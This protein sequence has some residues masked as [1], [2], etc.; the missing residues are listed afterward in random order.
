M[1]RLLSAVL[2]AGILL[3]CIVMAADVLDVDKTRYI[4]DDGFLGYVPDR[5]IVVLKDHVEVDHARE[6]QSPMA[7]SQKSG[8]SDLAQRFGVVH[9]R[10]QFLGSDL[11]ANANPTREAR[12][13]ARHYKVYLER[14][15]LDEAIKAYEQHPMVERVE[16]IGVHTVFATPNDP[17]YDDPPGGYAYDQ[18]HYWD[19][20]G[21][22]ADQAWN[23]ETGSQNVIVGDLD[24]GTKYDHGDLGGSNP[25]GP[26]DASTNGNIWINTNEVVGNGVDDDGNGYVDDILGWDFVESTDWYSYSCIDI[27]CGGADNDPSDGDGHGTHTAGTI[28]AITNNGYSVAGVAGGYGDGT[29]N[30]GGNGVKVVPCRI[31]YVLDYWIYGATGV[32]IMD[33][34]AEAMY[35]MADLKDAGWN[36]AAINCSFGSSNS[37]GLSS[38]ASYLIARDVVICVAAGNSSSSSASYLSS[39][40]DC[41]DVAATDQSGNPASFT[42]YGSWV[43]IA[44]P[45]VDVVSTITDPADPGGDYIAAMDGT[46]MSCPHVAGVVGLLESYNPSL[47]ATDKIN[48]ITDPANTNPYG[49]SLD[50]G[51]GIVDAYKCLQAAGGGCDLAADFSGSPT[52]GCEPLTVS[53]TDLSSGSGIDGWSWTFGDGGSS[54]SQNPNHTYNGPGTYSVSLTVSSSG[55]GCDDTETKT[56]YITVN[57]LPTA[58]FTG[59]PTSG[60]EPLTVDFTDQSSNATSW[61]W[62]FGDGAGT[63]T[64]QNPSYTYKSA[65][66]YTVT[67]TANNSCGSDVE[68]KVDYIT[69]DPCIAPT[70]AFTGS[71]TSGDAPLTVDFTDQSSNATSWSWDFGDGSGTSTQQN[72]SYTYDAPGT[73]TVTLTA[74]NS[75]GSDDEVKTD[76]ITVTCT[77]P[78]ANFTGSPTSGYAPLTVDFSDQSTGATSWSWDFGDGF[79]SSTQ[80]NPSYTYDTPGTYTVALTAANSCGNDIETK[81]NYI[82]VSEAPSEYATLPYSTGF[83]SGSFDAYWF[84][85]TSSSE[86]RIQITSSNSPRGSYH[87]TMDDNT[88]GGDYAQNEAWLKVDLAGKSDVEL[89]FWWKEFSD[90][91]HTQDGVFFSDNGGSSF[92]KVYNLTGGSTTYQEI[93]LD[94]DQL[95]SGAGLSLTSTFVIK[96]QQYD[97]YSITTDGM[98]FDDI[99]VT[100]LDAPPVADF[101]GSPTSGSFPLEVTFTDQSSGNPTSWNWDF[102]DGS[103]TSTQQNPTYTYNS[104][105]TYTVSLTVTNAFGSD[106]E[107][108]VDYITVTTPPPPTAD[109]SGDPTS[110]TAPLTV[111]FTDQSSGNPTSWSWDFGDGVGTSSAQNPSYTY[112]NPGTYTVSLAATNAYGS[113]TETKTDYITVNEAGQDLSHVHNIAVSHGS[114]WRWRYGSATVT[115]YDAG[116]SPLSNA[117]VYGVWSG[118]TGASA[119]GTTNSSGQ[120]TFTTGWIRTSSE[121]CFEVTDV[122]HSTHTYDPASNEVT[123]ACESGWVF[124]TGDGPMAGLEKELLPTEFSLDQNHPNPFNPSTEISFSLPAGT[125]VTLEIFNISG[126]KVTTL[127]DRYY[128]AGHH[129]VTWEASHA[130]SGVYLYRLTTEQAVETKKMLLLK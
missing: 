124:S 69:V 119:N 116:G 92:S 101:T 96:F 127:V 81:T 11:K 49:G 19:A 45:G 29:F 63:S 73:F 106:E 1:R 42:N 80:Q 90:E 89:T 22:N 54:N 110:G 10:P 100:S 12:S 15:N 48:I 14:E 25:P 5:F 83:E 76:Y 24:I 105:G 51:A 111:D 128:G 61:S 43:D 67:L 13:L 129:S 50:L 30:G 85:Q 9:S 71:P 39:R 123:K 122:T 46:S 109:F 102:G 55:Q 7:L 44:A 2:I 4:N 47:S 3:P 97:N 72:P 52:S 17:Y 130:A 88:N 36:V 125:H 60:T 77:A 115:I 28:A 56:S 20:N 118:P 93:V 117:T 82:T 57:P 26:N 103:G 108:K 6:M 65:G 94:L 53:F 27:D 121:F 70:A 104:A 31:G 38:A 33:Y 99:S 120:V 58:A 79:G 112:D 34:V 35:Y 84:T 98:A 32:V 78:V 66:T 75:C 87:L 62:D 8:F 107:V 114:F 37:G 16:K 74:T 68:E 113:D 21:I 40:G 59:S 91:D 64:Q 18:W 23:V 126:Q 86:G 41:L 95:A